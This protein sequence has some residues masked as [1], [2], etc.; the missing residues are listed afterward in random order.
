MTQ[1]GIA[2]D[3]RRKHLDYI[4]AVVTRMSAAS[5]TAKGW[6]LPVVTA[7]YGF[8]LTKKAF[9]IALLGIAAVLLFSLLDANYLRQEKAYRRLYDAVAR[10]TKTIP[11]FSLNPADA[12][13][14]G[15]A[16]TTFGA[17][18]RRG[19]ARWFPGADVWLSWSIAPFYGALAVIGLI[20]L[21]VA[22]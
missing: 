20:T 1:P 10:G 21:V 5:S 15:P 9:A 13:D 14:A 7:T 8:A 11:S 6:L 18:V 3:D 4:Q 12:E 2:A 22:R 19:L 16:A 17:K